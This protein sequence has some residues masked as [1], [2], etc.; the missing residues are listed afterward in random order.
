VVA[1]E[2]AR[3]YLRQLNSGEI[4]S[5]IRQALAEQHELEAYAIVLVKPATIPKTSSGKIQRSACRARFQESSLAVVGEWRQ[6]LA[7]ETDNVTGQPT[8]QRPG[9]SIGPSAA[10]I[11]AWLVAR[12]GRQLNIAPTEIDIREPFARYGLDSLAMVSL[13]GDLE[14]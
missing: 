14:T 10:A 3:P 13:A 8:Q 7:S 1:H 6:Q 9:R 11:Q 2:V 5:A 4:T 12:L